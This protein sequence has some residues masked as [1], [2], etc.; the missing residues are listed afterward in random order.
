MR[1]AMEVYGELFSGVNTRDQEYWNK[2]FAVIKEQPGHLGTF[3]AL[4]TWHL[5][6]FRKSHAREEGMLL[7]MLC[8]TAWQVLRNL[9]GIEGDERNWLRE[10]HKGCTDDIFSEDWQNSIRFLEN[11][12][13]IYKI[14][15]FLRHPSKKLGD[16]SW[17]FHETWPD[18]IRAFLDEAA[19]LLRS[20]LNLADNEF[21]P[22]S[23]WESE[24]QEKRLLHDNAIAANRA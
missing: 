3:Q 19:F 4:I 12:H 1:E 5:I 23:G 14:Q 6:C 15:T 17:V 18:D 16:Y 10:K 24:W 21:S 8:A 22:Q 20:I 9:I 13:R 7:V 11:M 2:N